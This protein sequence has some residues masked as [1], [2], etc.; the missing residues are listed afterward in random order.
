MFSRPW[1][2]IPGSGQS[3][4]LTTATA[5][6]F[7][8]A[9]GASTLGGQTYAVAVRFA[10]AATPYVGLVTITHAGTAATA[11][12][13]YPMSSNDPTTVFI[14]APGDKV[15]CYQASGGTVLAYLAELTR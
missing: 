3:L 15:S 6:T 4:S 2:I 1:R 12:T 9:L 7:A 8:N 10:P 11:S 13:D 5:A 14:C